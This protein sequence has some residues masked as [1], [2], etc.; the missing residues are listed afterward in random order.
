MQFNHL[1][2]I[3]D[4]LIPLIDVLTRAQLWR[5]LVLRAEAPKL[6]VPH[7][8]G[9]LI[10]AR[11]TERFERALTYGALTITDVVT[12]TLRQQ[13]VIN[14]PGQNDIAPSSLTMTIEEPLSETL[15]VRFAYE[16]GIHVAPDSMDAYY[17]KFR[18]SA[19]Q[20]ADIDTIRLIRQMAQEGRLDTDSD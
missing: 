15:F 3:N 4:P 13:I 10:S 1:I 5:G 7:L 11:G 18:H 6:F 16:D 12:L 20:E 17:D 8:D 2:E 14:V 9:C 19:Y